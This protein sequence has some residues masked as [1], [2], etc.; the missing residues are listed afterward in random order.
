MSEEQ[1]KYD[2]DGHII[3]QENAKLIIEGTMVEVKEDVG[4]D[5]N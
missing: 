1:P 5:D 3:V 4:S 2:E